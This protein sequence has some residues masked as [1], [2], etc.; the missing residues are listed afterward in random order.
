VARKVYMTKNGT[1]V[2]RVSKITDLRNV[3]G[4]VPKKHIEAAMKTGG[5][6]HGLVEEF[7]RYREHG[8]PKSNKVRL[9]MMAFHSYMNRTKA[10]VSTVNG[11]DFIEVPLVS[12]K[13]LFGG[14]P[15]AILCINGKHI[16]TDFKTTSDLK[17]CGRLLDKYNPQL[18]AYYGA[19]KEKGIK[20][21]GGQFL[22]L[23]TTTGEHKVKSY[24]VA[25]LEAHF[26]CFLSLLGVYRAEK[27]AAAIR[28]TEMALAA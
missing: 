14:T 19:C 15:D 5:V 7:L 18:G 20:L 9:A 26:E 24:S 3:E 16:L 25:S 17:K 12:E 28:K 23:C 6:T 13:H 21:D 1:V 27:K 8:L 4:Y 2:P 11:K 10:G 22:F